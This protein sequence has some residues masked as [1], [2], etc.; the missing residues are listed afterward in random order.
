LQE[1]QAPFAIASVGRT[2][3]PLPIWGARPHH[4]TKAKRLGWI[5]AA[6][7]GITIA[8]GVLISAIEALVRLRTG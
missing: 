6:A 8:F 7:I 2:A 5:V 4:L 3:L 1:E